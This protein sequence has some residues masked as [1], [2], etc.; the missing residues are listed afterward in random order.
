[1][2]ITFL[3]VPNLK[4]YFDLTISISEYIKHMTPL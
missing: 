4:G 2:I 1:M 3:I